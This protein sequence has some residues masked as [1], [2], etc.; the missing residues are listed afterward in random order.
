VE[1]TLANGLRVIVVRRASVPLVAA[2]LVVRSGSETDPATQP[3]VASFVADLLTQGTT[4]QG[5]GELAREIDALGAQ[6]EADA[7]WDATLVAVNATTPKFARAFELFGE[8]VRQPAFATAELERLRTRRLSELQLSYSDPSSLAQLVAARVLYGDAPYGH[9][10]S[11]TP[12]S[13]SAIRREAL[14]EFH[15]THYRPDNAILILGGDI[16]PERGFAEAERVFGSWQAPATVLP[17]VSLTGKP[18]K[19]RVVVVDRPDAGRAAIV[20]GRPTIARTSDDYFPGVIANAVLTGYSGRLNSEVR[21]KRGLSYGARTALNPRRGPGP[22][23][24]STLVDNARAAEGT[25]VVLSTV[26]GLAAAVVPA[27]ELVPRKA[28]VTGGFS[29][30][31]ETIGGLVG[32]VGALALYDLPL[33]RINAFIPDA[34]AVTPAQIRDFAS[35]HL[36][37]G[38]S[39]VVVG[40]AKLFVGDLR[41]AFAQVE[42]IPFDRLDLSQATLVR[43]QTARTQ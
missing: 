24:A 26:R 30:S 7:N 40:N 10:R 6:I 29:R 22:F 34:Q 21:I 23:L 19:A 43:S 32:Q 42:V 8:V 20:V 4:A 13:V 17:T 18:P 5:A 15:R 31:L 16:D 11:G 37:N 3:G 38:L 33:D 25:T 39:V 28:V 1:R 41:K 2:Q 12:Q 27:S 36:N 35:T 14:V 9:P